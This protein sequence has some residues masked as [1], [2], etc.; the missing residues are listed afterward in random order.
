MPPGICIINLESVD[1]HSDFEL[2]EHISL[3]VHSVFSNIEAYMGGKSSVIVHLLL[4]SEINS[5]GGNH[6]ICM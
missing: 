4:V 1:N 6:N 3:Y 2:Q 5:E